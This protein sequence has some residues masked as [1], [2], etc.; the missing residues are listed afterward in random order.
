MITTEFTKYLYNQVSSNTSKQW[1]KTAK[2]LEA[3][4][5]SVNPSESEK[6]VKEL[7]DLFARI[8]NDYSYPYRRDY[9]KVMMNYC[10]MTQDW[11]EY[12]KWLEV[13]INDI[14]LEDKDSTWLYFAFG[15]FLEETGK[16][17]KSVNNH[18]NGIQ[19]SKQHKDDYYL[20]LNHLGMGVSLQRMRQPDAAEYHLF[21]ALEIFK[22]LNDVLK[23]ADVHVNLG[24]C[25]DR[26]G[27]S[28]LAISHY[29]QAEQLLLSINYEFDIGRILYSLGIAYLRNNDFYNANLTFERSKEY[30]LKTNNDHFLAATLYGIAWLQYLKGNIEQSRDWIKES[31]KKIDTSSKRGNNFVMLP[32]IQGHIY[33]L[34]GAIYS[35][36]PEANYGDAIKYLDL[37][38]QAYEDLEETDT[39]LLNVLANRGR[40]YEYQ[41]DWDKA[42]ATFLEQLYKSRKISSSSV[43]GDAAIHLFVINVLRKSNITKWINFFKNIGVDGLINLIRNRIKYFQRIYKS[44]LQKNIKQKQ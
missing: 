30:C 39:Q 35:K 22:E 33:L 10:E 16:F 19:A 36:P 32:E 27:K 40:I 20:A 38:Q 5:L 6:G 2:K 18:L 26:N 1:I 14:D 21:I 44:K 31:I 41:E 25:Y 4:M 23:Q 9:C 24:S 28:K 12:G 15:R 13:E 17:R 34:A 43:I 29:K 3:K 11:R 37:A 8:I 42:E 7:R